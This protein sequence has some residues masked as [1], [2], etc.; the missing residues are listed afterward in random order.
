MFELS[1]LSE[2]FGGTRLTIE[3]MQRVAAAD[4]RLIPGDPAHDPSCI[5]SQPVRRKDAPF[6][7][8]ECYC[9]LPHTGISAEEEIFALMALDLKTAI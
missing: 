5:F 7:C 8:G 9:K 4:N 3:L 6:R 2:D 1:E